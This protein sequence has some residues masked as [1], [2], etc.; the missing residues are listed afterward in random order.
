MLYWH[1]VWLPP[2]D[3]WWHMVVHIAISTT[4]SKDHKMIMGFLVE[5]LNGCPY[6]YW[7]RKKTFKKSKQN[8]EK[9]YHERVIYQRACCFKSKPRHIYSSFHWWLRCSSPGN[10]S[11]IFQ[12]IDFGKGWYS[13]RAVEGEEG[14]KQSIFVNFEVF[15]LSR[16]K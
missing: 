6:C 1:K 5:H 7:M 14:N 13:V 15:W 10:L 16:V 11:A 8:K 4:Q 3:V 9:Q 2:W 12:E